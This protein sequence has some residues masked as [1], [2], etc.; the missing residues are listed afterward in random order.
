MKNIKG[1][2]AGVVVGLV[3]AGSIVTYMKKTPDLMNYQSVNSS[4]LSQEEKDSAY[5]RMSRLKCDEAFRGNFLKGTIVYPTGIM[6]D[7]QENSDSFTVLR[8]V[9]VV[10]KS[11]PYHA[12]YICTFYKNGA[13]PYIDS[14][15]SADAKEILAKK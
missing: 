8:D 13:E 4:W 14:Q 12:K 5:E 3:V 1:I 7:H 10:Y 11:K 15:I 2:I 6:D 9:A